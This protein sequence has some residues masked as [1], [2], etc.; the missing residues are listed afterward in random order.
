MRCTVGHND[1]ATRSA[2]VDEKVRAAGT[3]KGDS[4]WTPVGTGGKKCRKAGGQN[5]GGTSETVSANELR[6]LVVAP[7]EVDDA[8]IS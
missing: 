2:E 3:G 6:L 4:K 1:L 8:R 5:F 7:G